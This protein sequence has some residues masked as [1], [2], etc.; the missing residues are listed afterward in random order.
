LFYAV[1]IVLAASLLQ[2][3]TPFPVLTWIVGWPPPKPA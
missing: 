3:L 1:A 2:F